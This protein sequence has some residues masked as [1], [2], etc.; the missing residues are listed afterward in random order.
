MQ[1]D[2]KQ[3]LKAYQTAIDRELLGMSRIRRLK[4][5]RRI[6]RLKDTVAAAF[7]SVFLSSLIIF[8]IFLVRE[9]AQRCTVVRSDVDT[10]RTIMIRIR[11]GEL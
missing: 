11:R 9:R 8:G 10:L 1:K 7:G 6:R 2:L 4:G 3:G 5:M